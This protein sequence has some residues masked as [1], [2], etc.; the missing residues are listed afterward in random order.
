MARRGVRLQV[1]VTQKGNSS[2]KTVVANVALA[3]KDTKKVVGYAIGWDND[4]RY[5][6]EHTESSD[7]FIG[8]GK[9][10]TAKR[11]SKASH[12]IL[13]GKV[14]R[15]VHEGFTADGQVGGV[16]VK[17][18][19][20]EAR[21]FMHNANKNATRDMTAIARRRLSMAPDE[22]KFLRKSDYGFIARFHR[23]RIKAE[24]KNGNAYHPNSEAWRKRKHPPK[25]PL[26]NT[27]R[28]WKTVNYKVLRFAEMRRLYF[29]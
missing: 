18:I 22:R 10:K 1:K 13:V 29:S 6:R 2:L 11:P 7:L 14:A 4:T 15:Y 20:V 5:D 19:E 12:T 17:G 26:I 21:P 24:L 8:S 25:V 23:Q 16:S 28:M 27:T 9:K 3:Q